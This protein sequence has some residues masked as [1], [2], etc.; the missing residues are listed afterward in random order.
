MARVLIVDDERS[1]RLLLGDLVRELGHAVV[2]A[3][4]VAAARRVVLEE[5][6]EVVL[7]DQRMPDGTGFDVLAMVAERDPTA[8]VVFLTAHGTIELA[9]DAM[10]AGAFDFITKPF[11]DAAVEG[12]IGRA[13]ERSRLVRENRLL[14]DQLDD[15]SGGELVGESE[16]M[17]ALKRAIARAAPTDASVLVLGETGSG[18]ELV[19]RAIHSA[20]ER[21]ERPFVPINCAAVPEALLEGTLFGHER[22]AFTG[23][24]SAKQGLFEAAD[25]GTVFLDEIGEMAPPLQAKLLR[26]LND[27]EL[28]RV[29]SVSPRK[30]DVRV[31][32][33]THRDLDQSMTAGA[34][35]EDL[36]YRLAVVPM[37]VPPLRER[38]DDVER[39]AAVF[40]ERAARD[41]KIDRPTLSGEALARLRG[42]AW[43]G[44]V[45]ELRNVIERACILGGEVIEAS[46]LIIRLSGTGADATGDPIDALA[47][48]LG[49]RFDLKATLAEI[50][51]RLLRRVLDACGGVRAEAARRLGMSRSDMT[52]KLGKLNDLADDRSS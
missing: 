26:V 34:F 5:R 37:R 38:G 18:K 7:T 36:F 12:V 13:V 9:V 32:A 17:L 46:D 10:R 4:G 3:E 1:M 35:R 14:R 33:A 29:G 49:D 16:P 50:E 11:E 31:I 25:G 41:M 51:T 20:S 2:E 15:V 45:R 21:S 23:A 8:A 40:L 6:F 42:Y 30:V 47:R 28:L 22:G 39:L 43:P 48:S 44:N 19:A 27:G 24:D 52:Y